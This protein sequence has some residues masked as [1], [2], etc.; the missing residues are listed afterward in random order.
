M[1]MFTQKLAMISKK[2]TEL[3]YLPRLNAIP[4][5]LTSKEIQK[6]L[7]NFFSL[8]L[9]EYQYV[10]EDGLYILKLSLDNAEIVYKIIKNEK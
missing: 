10:P 9:A 8:F 6:S 3:S 2:S 4:Q 5:R 1:L 7:L